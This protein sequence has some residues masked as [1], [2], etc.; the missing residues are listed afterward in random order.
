MFNKILEYTDL[1]I[2]GLNVLLFPPTEVAAAT[3]S[4][5]GFISTASTGLTAVS[6]L[7]ALLS[8]I[9]N[10]KAHWT[11]KWIVI[12]LVLLHVAAI[13]VLFGTA[14][15][16]S[17]SKFKEIASK[18]MKIISPLLACAMGGYVIYEIISAPKENLHSRSIGSI[19]YK[20]PAIMALT[21][22]KKTPYYAIVIIIRTGGL[23]TKSVG[24]FAEMLEEGQKKLAEGTEK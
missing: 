9:H 15:S 10:T 22:L 11:I 14:A 3:E 16:G 13:A 12:P 23:I 8:T 1:G 20:L 19:I 17:F 6:S 2:A 4:D 21:P 18:G 5:L 24:G 7:S